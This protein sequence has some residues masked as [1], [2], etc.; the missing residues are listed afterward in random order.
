MNIT[1]SIPADTRFER[2]GPELLI[3]MINKQY[4]STF[5]PGELVFDTPSV[6]TPADPELADV[7]PNTQV[8]LRPITA[9]KA[10]GSTHVTYSRLNLEDYLGPNRS[11]VLT[12]EVMTIQN[13]LDHISDT[14]N[15]A[16]SPDD[17]NVTGL[18]DPADETGAVVVTVTPV[19]GHLIWN[20]GATFEV[21]PDNH[22]GIEITQ[23]IADGLTVPV[24]EG[25]EPTTLQRAVFRLF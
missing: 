23:H 8:T 21:V 6:Q 18:G 9:T 5:R 24:V 1:L 13:L 2:S 11:Y 17:V 10:R 16:L 25:E 22:L 15:V 3:D 12:D 4:G 14:W 19:A 20:A 7:V